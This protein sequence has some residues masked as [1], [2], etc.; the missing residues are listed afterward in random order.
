MGA[1]N[2]HQVILL[3]AKYYWREFVIDIDFETVSEN[4]LF[5]IDLGNLKSKLC[6]CSSIQNP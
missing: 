3:K 5:E 4:N 2:T 1:K 6:S